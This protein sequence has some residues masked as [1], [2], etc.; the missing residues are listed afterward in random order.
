MFSALVDRHGR[1]PK[2]RI[3]ESADRHR[4]QTLRSFQG[5]VDRGTTGGAEA[6]RDLRSLIPDS[7]VFN[8]AAADLESEAG[9]T[10]LLAEYT[11][12]SPLAG[13]AVA[14]GYAKRFPLHLNLK[15]TAGALRSAR[16]HPGGHGRLR[17]NT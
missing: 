7:N 11:A 6:K 4:N 15:L 1:R 12:G 16:R 3:R 14:Y 9:K 13:Q 10:S 5:V 8:T 2:L 17:R